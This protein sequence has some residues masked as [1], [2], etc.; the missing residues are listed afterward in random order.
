MFG[1][2][3]TKNMTTVKG[4]IRSSLSS[5][6][7]YKTWEDSRSKKS[8]RDITKRKVSNIKAQIKKNI[9]SRLCSYETGML[10][11]VTCLDATVY[12]VTTLLN[13]ISDT[14]QDLT[15]TDFSDD[16]SW[17][18]VT[19]L[20]NNIFNDDMNKVRCF[21]RKSMNTHSKEDMAAAVLVGTFQTHR[22]M[23][24]YMKY[25]IDNHTSISS[26][27]VKFLMTNS[28]SRGETSGGGDKLDGLEERMTEVEKVTK[29][30]NS[31]AGSFS[32]TANQ[33]KKKVEKIENRK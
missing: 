11:F 9:F 24:E 10:L 33:L 30:L 4:F 6:P 14:H 32:N 2:S 3:L 23:E 31:T 26:E 29:G 13:F 21:F 5:L 7:I 25:G 8:L 17:Q 16:A 15:D 22:V 18:L 12:F 27:Y 28:S 19:Q 1:G 20:V